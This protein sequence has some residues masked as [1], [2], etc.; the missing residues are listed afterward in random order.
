MLT[1]DDALS[2]ILQKTEDT[3]KKFGFSVVTPAGAQKGDLPVFEDG[4]HTYMDFT[5]EK[6][7]LR[8]EIFGAQALLFAGDAKAGDAA[9]EDLTKI[10]TS[11]FDLE[12]F[13]ERD[14]RS[15]C[16]EFNE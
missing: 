6:G 14:I 1:R 10:S 11:Y 2:L 13:D 16:N 8:I 3:M 15:R 12:N 7:K 9:D 5:G 4:E